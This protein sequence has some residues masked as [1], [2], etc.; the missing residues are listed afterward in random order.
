MR[1]V[2]RRINVHNR[3]SEY[4]AGKPDPTIM[5]ELNQVN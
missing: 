4:V 2:D 5:Q 1:D 3:L